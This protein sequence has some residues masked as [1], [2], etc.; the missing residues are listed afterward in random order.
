[1]VADVFT[2]PLP[3]EKHVWC[4]KRLGLTQ[5]EDWV[6]VGVLNYWVD[7]NLNLLI[8]FICV[9]TRR[10]ER[11]KNCVKRSPFEEVIVLCLFGLCCV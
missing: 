6:K 8:I 11:S 3:K 2:K 4:M 7:I 10:F 9:S 1:M 5:V